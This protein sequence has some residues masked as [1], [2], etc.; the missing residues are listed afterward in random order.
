MQN[1]VKKWFPR[2][3]PFGDWVLHLGQKFTYKKYKEKRKIY[4][5]E[6]RKTTKYRKY[7][8]E[9]AKTSKR[10]NYLKEWRKKNRKR[11]NEYLKNYLKITEKKY[12]YKYKK[13]YNNPKTIIREKAKKMVK[14][15]KITECSN[16]HFKK[17]LHRHHPDYTKP[18]EIVVL[19]DKC[20]YE[21]HRNNNP[22]YPKNI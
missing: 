7:Q 19:C 1:P 4:L 10:I 6:Y 20:H 8:R 2:R 12:K 9:Y 15:V 14:Y 3:F 5:K 21:W 22:I 11:L 17:N 18:L 16:C 13:D